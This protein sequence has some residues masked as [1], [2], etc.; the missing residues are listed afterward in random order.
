M[1]NKERVDFQ[2]LLFRPKFSLIGCALLLFFSV[3]TLGAWFIAFLPF[4]IEVPMDGVGQSNLCSWQMTLSNFMEISRQRTVPFLVVFHI[5]ALIFFFRLAQK[6]RL[7]DLLLEFGVL[8]LLA[9]FLGVIVFILMVLIDVGIGYIV[10][11]AGRGGL[12]S[13]DPT[14]TLI[15]GIVSTAIVMVGLFISQVTGWVRSVFTQLSRNI[16]MGG[17]LLLLVLSFG[18][19]LF[20]WPFV[21]HP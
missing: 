14:P 21:L 8:N 11:A 2:K 15:P 7:A 12:L 17:L 5:S 10:N 18:C 19:F 20:S 1:P 3:F 6:G 13:C 9:P 4:T 16:Q